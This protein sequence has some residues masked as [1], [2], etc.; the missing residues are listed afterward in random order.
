MGDKMRQTALLIFAAL[1]ASLAGAYY[2]YVVPLQ[3][4]QTSLQVRLEKLDQSFEQMQSP[5]AAKDK[6][7]SVQLVSKIQEAIPV[8][9]YADQL[10]KDLERL[11]SVSQVS[12]EDASF[13]E[14]ENLSA[15]ELADELI[16]TDRDKEKAD[17]AKSEKELIAAA[18]KDLK[19]GYSDDTGS[20]ANSEQLEGE[21]KKSSVTNSD[22]QVKV[23]IIEKY[24]PQV[25]FN[26]ITILLNIKGDYNEIYRFVTELQKI[27]RYLRVDQLE[28]KSTEKDEF[29]VPKETKMTA[30]VKLTS[31]FAPQFEKYVDK[32]PA[33]Q[34]E[35]P[36]DKWNPMLYEIM[37]KEDTPFKA[38]E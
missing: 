36:S 17:Q 5:Q 32:L 25:H 8:K 26:S 12:I 37:K 19:K 22:R 38:A 31:Y 14:Q 23:D 33:V 7:N 11:Q 15:K 29:V 21:D 27:S 34:V 1:F 4:E 28:F 3:E 13:S 10:I 6:Q 16:Y 24:L 2:L 20:S 35:G 9:P 18:N 30:T